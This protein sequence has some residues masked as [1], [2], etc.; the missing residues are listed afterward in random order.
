VQACN[1]CGG[2]GIVESAVAERYRKGEE[3]RNIR[4][5]KLSLTQQQL[6]RVLRIPGIS[7]GEQLNAIRIV[8]YSSLAAVLALNASV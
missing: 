6:A 2:L 4:V 7:T 5:R 1:F 3:L 8:L